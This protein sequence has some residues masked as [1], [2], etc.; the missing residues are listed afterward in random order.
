M[1][2]LLL[3]DQLCPL[4]MESIISIQENSDHYSSQGPY[5]LN[6]LNILGSLLVKITFSHS[7]FF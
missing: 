7:N 3:M 2:S 4:K 5:A 1:A 6:G